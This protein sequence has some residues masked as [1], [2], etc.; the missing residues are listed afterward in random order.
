MVFIEFKSRQLKVVLCNASKYVCDMV[1]QLRLRYCKF[2]FF[3][4]N[5]LALVFESFSLS[6]KWC[7]AS[8]FRAEFMMKKSSRSVLPAVLIPLQGSLIHTLK[9]N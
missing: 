5:A 7:I 4:S 6:K 9:K 1:F 2:L 3:I 8:I